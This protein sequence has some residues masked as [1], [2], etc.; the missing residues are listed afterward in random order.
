MCETSL[1]KITQLNHMAEMATKDNPTPTIDALKYL[2]AVRESFT[3]DE[4]YKEFLSRLRLGMSFQRESKNF[5][6]TAHRL[7]E[8]NIL[9]AELMKRRLRIELGGRFMETIIS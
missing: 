9:A 4:K 7:S 1:R 5:T 8:A 2:A 6:P 3:G